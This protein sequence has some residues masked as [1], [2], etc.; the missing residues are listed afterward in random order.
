MAD[1]HFLNRRAVLYS[2]VGGITRFG[3]SCEKGCFAVVKRWET[4]AV[5]RVFDFLELSDV[6]LFVTGHPFKTQQLTPL[7]TG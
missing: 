4:W 1:V 2:A 3:L 6:G 5:D 7:G